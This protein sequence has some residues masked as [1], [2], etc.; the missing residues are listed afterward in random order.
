MNVSN[1][2]EEARKK[3]KPTVIKT[4]PS[5]NPGNN[6]MDQDIPVDQEFTLNGENDQLKYNF[7][8]IR[9][10]RP[11]M[12]DAHL[13]LRLNKYL[14]LFGI[15]DGH[16]GKKVS[17]MLVEEL[18]KVF[19][20]LILGIKPE[21]YDQENISAALE[22]TFDQLDPVLVKKL[23]PEETCQ[24]STAAVVIIHK[25]F[26]VS[27]HCGDSKIHF[28]GQENLNENS[29]SNENKTKVPP[30]KIIYE[31]VNHSPSNEIEKSRIYANGGEVFMNRISTPRVRVGLAVAR[32]F[33]DF[34]Y[35]K[36]SPEDNT[37]DL[38]ITKADMF[39]YNILQPQTDEHKTQQKLTGIMICCDGVTDVMTNQE[40]MN[41]F[42]ENSGSSGELVRQAFTKGSLDNI[43]CCCINFV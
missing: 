1:I 4:N 6:R 19:K 18:P 11:R 21:N 17:Q 28:Y 29:V 20:T 37:L 27:A 10:R 35:K 12:E 38:V 5:Q 3:L 26:V 34:Q 9:G 2:L 7:T 23:L 36:L 42:V 33:G 24:G 15:F 32:S 31:S 14:C 13:A 8:W 40:I 16:G 41:N 25:N 43:S 22:K 30:T 39:S